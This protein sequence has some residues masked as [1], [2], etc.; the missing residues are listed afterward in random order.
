MVVLPEPDSP[1]SASTSPFSSEKLTPLT[2]SS[3]P[4]SPSATTRRSCTRINWLISMPSRTTAAPRGQPVD[5]QVDADGQR[6]D[7]QCRDHDGRSALAEAADVLAYQR[8]KVGVRR[9]YTEPQKAHAAEQ[10]DDEAE[11]QAQ[12]GHDRVE[13]VRQDF[14]A[15]NVDTA[16]AACAR[17]LHVLQRLDVHRQAAGDP[18]RAW[19][20]AQYRRADEQH[21][22]RAERRDHDQCQHFAGDRDERVH[23][24]ADDFV[25]PFWRDHRQ[26]RTQGAEAAGQ[27]GRNQ[28][29]TD[30]EAR[31]DQHAAE[32]VAA[33]VIS[34]E[35]VGCAHVFEHV[36][37]DH[38]AHRMRREPGAEQGDHQP[39]E[40]HR[41]AQQAKP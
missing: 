32:H 14:P 21:F 39:D 12:V 13:H 3:S 20:V 9:L 16:L 10:Q 15:G 19:R 11:A 4:W 25:Q 40:A 24:A 5:E 28:C 6:A 26:Q 35:R 36:V 30:G 37:G 23:Q 22:G 31:T 34:A 33:Q 29:Q 17:H 41:S 38:F 8:A 2:I 18:K 7:G 27:H 1:I